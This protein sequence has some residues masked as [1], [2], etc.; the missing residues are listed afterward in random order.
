M[1][2]IIE[3][4]K[5]IKDIV[6]EHLINYPECRDSD[7]LLVLKIWE[8]QGYEVEHLIF[9]KK[10]LIDFETIRR[11]RQHIQSDGRLLPLDINIAM[12]RIDDEKKLREHY[13][14]L[15]AY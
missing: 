4:H 8:S 12:R 9:N 5:R 6:E 2:D 7:I 11:S 1:P 15:N 13:G 3:H 14:K 10:L